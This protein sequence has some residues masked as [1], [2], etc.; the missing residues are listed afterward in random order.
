E[1]QVLLLEPGR[2]FGT[3]LHATTSLVAELLDEHAADLA[4]HDLLDVGTGSGILA[5]VALRL[6]AA[7]AVAI[8]DD[9][10]VIEAVLEN[11]ARSGL[12]ARI[13]ASAGTVDGVTRQFPWV[14]E[15]IEARVLRPLAPELARVVSP[16]RWLIL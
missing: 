1:E 5:L 12:A 7:S 16:G 15:N 11:A 9:A 2:A 3:G 14:D 4:G 8:D 13:T 10:D 6:G